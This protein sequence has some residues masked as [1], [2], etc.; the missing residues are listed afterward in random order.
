MD[1][2]QAA[3]DIKLICGD[4]KILSAFSKKNI[5]NNIDLHRCF[6]IRYIDN[7]YESG[8]NDQLVQH[9]VVVI[10]R[11][12]KCALKTSDSGR[13]YCSCGMIDRI[14]GITLNFVKYSRTK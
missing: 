1:T 6:P 4:K 14:T 7:R 12:I 13:R 9:H 8:I 10:G 11:L 5:T 2:N 3:T